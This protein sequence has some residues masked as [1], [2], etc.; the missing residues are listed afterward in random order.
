VAVAPSPAEARPGAAALVVRAALVGTVLVA[1]LVLADLSRTGGHP[2]GLIQPGSESLTTPVLAEDFPDVDIPGGQG[3]DGQITYTIARDPFRVE[4]TAEHLGR[5]RYRLQRPLLPW[6]AGVVQPGRGGESL[7]W[8]LFAVGLLAVAAGAWAMG[9]LAQ[10]WG[11]SPWLGLAFPLLPG[12]YMAL[13]VTTSD[14]VGVGLALLAVALAARNRTTAAVGVGVL[15]VLA[16]EPTWLV[17]A[18]WALAHR[19]PRHVAVA[20]V[21]ALVGGSW[22][23]ALRLLVPGSESLNGDIG[24]PGAGLFVAARDIWLDGRELW[25]LASTV[26]ALLLAVLA[27]RRSGLR[28]PLGWAVAVNLAFL[29]VAGPNPLGTSFGGTRTALALTAVALITLA[30]PSARRL[31]PEPVIRSDGK[32]SD[33]IAGSVVGAGR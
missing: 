22:M 27:L 31:P 1:T 14:A 19:T 13:R 21:P 3:L 6:V 28:H 2:L 32:P 33:L 9:D 16:K 24:A 25:G 23:L 17:L 8:S 29:L 18:G 30:T 7:I 5:P 15:A 11:G 4:S 26:A 20:A 12:T 10:R